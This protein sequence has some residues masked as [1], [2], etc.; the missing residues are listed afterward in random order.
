MKNCQETEP[1]FKGFIDFDYSIGIKAVAPQSSALRF[2]SRVSGPLFWTFFLFMIFIFVCYAAYFVFIAFSPI[3]PQFFS[4][5]LKTFSSLPT[6]ILI[7]VSALIASHLSIAVF[8]AFLN[9]AVSFAD[10]YLSGK[11]L[12]THLLSLLSP[13][14]KPVFWITVVFL[15]ALILSYVFGY[16]YPEVFEFLFNFGGLPEDGSI[17]V[18]FYI[19]FNNT[20]IVFLLIFLGFLFGFLP[21]S[22]ILVNG[23]T[24]GIVA[25][26]TI[27]EEGLL[28]LLTGLLPHGI[29]EIPVILLGAGVGY[30]SGV[31][32]SRTL[33]KRISFASFKQSF[34]DGTWI[35]FLIAV[36]LL[37]I[38]AV[39]E[40]Y[41][42]SPLLGVIW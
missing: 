23:F 29:V 14:T 10:F 40:V 16:F 5:I 22:I 18:M 36:P 11:S 39:I 9:F 15:A 35:F 30:Y 13:V 28:F 6:P 17:S 38:A 20:R 33:M 8:L 3:Y 7:V 37:F 2:L 12:K 34:I 4:S 27:K 24:V 21:V 25:E 1:E 26:Y 32:A 31:L 41:V 19:F 42:T